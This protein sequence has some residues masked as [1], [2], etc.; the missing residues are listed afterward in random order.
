VFALEAIPGKLKVKQSDPGQDPPNPHPIGCPDD[1]RRCHIVCCGSG[2]MNGIA[3]MLTRSL[4]RR[5]LDKT[6]RTG[7]YYF[8]LMKWAGDDSVASSLPSLPALLR[9][10]FGLELKS[11]RGSVPVLVIDRVAK[12]TAN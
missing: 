5:V 1:D 12:P 10:E 3:G 8:G 7:S 9:D 11:E 4:G 6:G 2:T